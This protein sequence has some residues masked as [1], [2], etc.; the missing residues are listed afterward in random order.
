MT[1]TLSANEDGRAD[2]QFKRH[3]AA[4]HDLEPADYRDLFDLKRDYPMVASDYAAQHSAMAKK[5]GLGRKPP[6]RKKA[7]SSR[8]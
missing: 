7:A 6:T 3:L 5:T 2:R 4:T 1:P 8:R